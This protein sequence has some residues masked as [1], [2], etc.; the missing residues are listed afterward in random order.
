MQQNAANAE[1]SA[2]AS[3]ELGSQAQ[4]LNGM[5]ADLTAIVTGSSQAAGVRRQGTGDRRQGHISAPAKNEAKKALPQHAGKP[6]HKAAK[7]EEVIPL[8]DSELSK[9]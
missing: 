4:E 5:V 1:E 2:S 9:F 7:A 6:A 3:E 8:D